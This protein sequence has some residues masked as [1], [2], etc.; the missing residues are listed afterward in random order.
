MRSKE[1]D[2]SIWMTWPIAREFCE[3]L[4]T[5][6]HRSDGAATGDR[7]IRRDRNG[8]QGGKEAETIKTRINSD[9]DGARAITAQLSSC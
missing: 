5:S 6:W 3:W 1:S 7:D 2:V 8:A 9:S 4:Q